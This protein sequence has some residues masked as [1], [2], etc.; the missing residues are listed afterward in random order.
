MNAANGAGTS[1]WSNVWNFT[2]APPKPGKVTLSSPS[3][4]VVNQAQ[5][6]TLSWQG[7]FG[8]VSYTLQVST[9][10]DFSTFAFNQSSLTGTSQSVGPLADSVEF[11]W[12]VNATNA[13]G[14]GS[15][16]DV[17]NF[18][19]IPNIPAQV[20]LSSPASGTQNAL[21]TPTLGWSVTPKAAS[22]TLQVSTG[23]D[24]SSTVTSMSGLPGLAEQVGPLTDS[25]EYY[26]RVNATN[27]GGTGSWSNV[28]N[29]TTIPNIPAQVALSSPASGTQNASLTPTLG[30]SVTPKAAS[31]TLQVS[32]RSD[33]SS[34]VTSMSGLPGL[35]EQVGPLTDSVEYYWRVNA[36]NA[37]GTGSWSLVWNFTTI[38]VPVLA[39][40]TNGTENSSIS[41]VLSWNSV[42]T[43]TSYRLDVST[44]SDFS[45]TVYSEGSLTATSQQVTGL[46]NV[47]TY[48]WRVN[49]ANSGG[50]T[51]WSSVWSFA[52]VPSV[53]SLSSPANGVTDEQ[54]T[55]VTLS[56]SGVTGAVSYALHVSTDSQFGSTVFAEKLTGTTTGTAVGGLVNGVTYYWKVGAKDV[57]GVVSGW[58]SVWSFATVPSVVSLSSPANGVT[59]E[60]PTAVT[61]SWSGVTGAVSYALHVSTDSQFGSTVFAEKL[62]GTTTGTAVGGLVNGVTYYWKVG[63]KD[64]Y[65]V[66]S[67]WSSVWSFAT[68]PSVVSLSSPANGVTDEQP[69]AVTLSWSGVTG[70]VSYALHVSTDSQFGSTVFAEKLTGTTTGTAVGGLVNGVTYYWKVGAKDVYGVVSGWSSVWSF[71]TVPSVVSLSSPANGVTDE[72]PTAVTLSWSGVTGAV[73]YALHVS[74]DSQFGSTVFA[75]KLTGTTTGTA[76]GGLVNGV[77]YYWKVGAKDVYGVVSGWS[78]VWSFATV[79]SVVSLSSPANGVTD[80]QPTAVT[81]SW[82]G[83]T[84]AVSYALHVSTDSQFGSTVFA[85]KLTG[86]TTGTAVGGLVNGVTYYWKVG[87]KDVYG[88]VSGWSSVWSFATVPSVVSLS[89]PA[90]GVTDEQPTAV[91]LSWSGVTGAVSYALHVSTDSQFGSTVFAEKLTGTT[92]GTAV[93]GLVNGVTYYWK[94]G[95]KDVYGVVSGWS[96]VWSFATV[97]S[98]VSLSSPANGVTDEQPTAVTL[99]WSGV[100][101]AVSYALH[102]STDSQFGSTVFAE[103]LTGTTT[104][105]A[106]GGLV[107]GVTYYWKVG[108]KDVY[109]VVSGWSSVWSFA[110]VPSVVS[111]SSPANG[112]TDEQPTAV[113]LSWSGVTG[114]VSYALHVSTDSQFGSTVFAEKLTGTTTG[115]AVGGLVNGV[116]YYWKVGAKDVY[117][118]VSGWSSVWSFA[119]VPSVVSLSS[120]ASGVTDEQPTAVTLSWSGVTGAVSYALHVSTDSQFGST[121]FAEKLTGTTTGT[122]VGGLVNGVTYYW[123]VGAKDVYGVVSG[124]SSVWSFATI[125]AIAPAPVLASPQNG[126]VAVP[127]AL[128]VSWE[129]TPRA[130]TYAM[131][132]STSSAFA[133]TVTAQTGITTTGA[134]IS[135]LSNNATYYW[136]VNATNV[137]GTSAWSIVSTF[138]TFLPYALQINA[139]WNMVSFN[140]R[141]AD[142]CIDSI[143]HVPAGPDG[144]ILVKD[145]SGNSYIPSLGVHYPFDTLHTGQGYQVY[146]SASDTISAHGAVINVA[147]TPISLQQGWNMIGYLPQTDLS[148]ETVFQPIGSDL[149]FVKNNGGHVYWPYFQVDDIDSMLVGQGYLVYMAQATTLTYP[150]GPAKAAGGR[151]MLRLPNPKHYAFTL[152]TGNNATLLARNVTIGGKAVAD[153]GEIGAFNEEGK[154]VGG[155]TVI[156]G[157]AAFAIWG[158][159]PQAGEKNGCGTSGKISFKLWDGA[160]EYPLEFVQGASGQIRYSANAVF[161]GSLAVPEGF[162][163]K[164]FDLS[165]VYPNPFRGSLKIAFDVPTINGVSLHSIEINLYDVKGNL[166]HQMAK[167]AYQAGHYLIA[168]DGDGADRVGAGLYI[169]QMKAQ[170]FDKR[171]QLIR[172]R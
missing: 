101:G 63:A 92:T 154:L 31:F 129:T 30:W 61:L 105:T 134:A 159:D 110:T 116:T 170:N 126:V 90:N 53:V 7:A 146:S 107:N 143:I 150:T 157:I 108:A 6:L 111:L 19:T 26:W 81:L 56:W 38:V 37:G 167:G 32:T 120:P 51:G 39:L 168:W 94:V 79:P 124:W 46:A 144:F 23:S 161:M 1:A 25:V 109:G 142:S 71:A 8:A 103:K 165:K 160:Q 104:G 35:A 49:A 18:T 145:L 42:T 70:A 125:V 45:T 77:T 114:A 169:I 10:T 4:N 91:T 40:P 115:T 140:V 151:T 54:P 41:P 73:S 171:I 156:H 162:L 96:S 95:A 43:A 83:V 166:V 100:T 102:V 60:Q 65:G 80:E 67:G 72:Q 44:T 119:T 130:V 112:V 22:F 97:P 50:I 163:I 21:L 139:G 149:E 164:K 11:Y 76:V 135:G 15:W 13:G 89:S 47:I 86:T 84:G 153:N 14:A 122:A 88:V 52:T 85:E 121:V 87:A 57:Y 58:S 155:G 5:T 93:G 99:S 82:S 55:A 137:G 113:T 131:Q 59:D 9:G 27:A 3:N 28:W 127:V 2:T 24:F 158:N 29:F 133:T 66:V 78:S 98:V 12:R 152:N 20:A 48:Y 33:F 62:T 68:V 75:E 106:V 172:V 147:A 141:F 138:T 118:V 132:V 36:T 128:T 17:W 148:V 74:T 117:G 64:V 34:T 69:T 123:K 136:R 16:S